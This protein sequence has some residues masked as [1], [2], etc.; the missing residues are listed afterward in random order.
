MSKGIICKI[1]ILDENGNFIKSDKL[2]NIKNEFI[3]VLNKYLPYKQ[4]YFETSNNGS[5][6]LPGITLKLDQLNKNEK[7]ESIIPHELNIFDKPS[8]QNNIYK[9]VN[10]KV[11]N[12]NK[13]FNIQ[14]MKNNNMNLPFMQSNQFN[15]TMI[16]TKLEQIN[17]MYMTPPPMN[18][19]STNDMS[20]PPMNDM[21]MTPPQ[22][23]A[24]IKTEIIQPIKI[25]SVEMPD[26][27][28]PIPFDM[29]QLTS[30]PID[31]QQI[32]PIQLDNGNS[33]ISEQTTRGPNTI[34]RG[35]V[36]RKPKLGKNICKQ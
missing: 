20:P 2:S 25:I 19:S 10:L 27:I 16:T 23:K 31:Y 18:G 35:I 7:A 28:I 21:S 8:N 3:N 34:N 30:K 11:D 14:Q 4:V 5:N 22:N 17:D 6:N 13:S 32:T 15:N 24:I 33:L 9:N 12:E 1:I 29:A 26:E 36:D